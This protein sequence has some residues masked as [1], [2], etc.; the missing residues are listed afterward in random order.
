MPRNRIPVPFPWLDLVLFGLMVAM[1][2][3]GCRGLRDDAVMNSTD[4]GGSEGPWF[5]SMM[6]KGSSWYLLGAGGC[7]G[8][9]HNIRRYQRTGQL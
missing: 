6:V 2:V 5:L 7:G 4:A 3:L 9:G 8:R 1:A